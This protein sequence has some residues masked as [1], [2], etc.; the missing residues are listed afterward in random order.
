MKANEENGQFTKPSE[1]RIIRILPGPIERVWD[2]LTDPEKRSRWFA[3][4]P[5][6]Q[7]NGGKMTLYFHHKNLAPQETPPEPYAKFHDPGASMEGTVLRCEP[8]HLLSYTFGSSGD[9]D[10]TFELTEQGKN[11]MLVLTHRSR[12][13]DVPD[14][15]DFGAGW[16]THVAHLVALLEGDKAPPFWPMHASLKPVYERLRAAAQGS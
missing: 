8:P 10:V 3:G 6:E 11:V 14:M 7:R 9:S 2:F 1:L 15:G 12:G 13:E 4:G 5:M 16:H